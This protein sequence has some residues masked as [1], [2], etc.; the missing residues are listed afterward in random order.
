MRREAAVCDCV[1]VYVEMVGKGRVTE[2]RSASG[3][4]GKMRTGV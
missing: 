3:N 2:E 1:C 4:L